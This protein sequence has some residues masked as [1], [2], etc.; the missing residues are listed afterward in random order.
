MKKLRT[1][2]Q[3]RQPKAKDNLCNGGVWTRSHDPDVQAKPFHCAVLA[4]RLRLAFF[5]AGLSCSNRN[6]K[7]ITDHP[8]VGLQTFFFKVCWQLAKVTVDLINSN[9]YFKNTF[10]SQKGNSFSGQKIIPATERSTCP[11]QKF[12]GYLVLYNSTSNKLPL[13]SES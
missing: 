1:K 3:P 11:Q 7:C 12:T 10:S 13:W 9:P 6:Q 5:S 8:L 2:S 4:P